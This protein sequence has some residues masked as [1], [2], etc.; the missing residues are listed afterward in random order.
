LL[1]VTVG[2]VLLIVRF[3]LRKKALIDREKLRPFECGFTPKNFPRIPLSI[4]FFLVSLV[5]LVFDVELI[6]I[7]PFIK[8]LLF[9][10]SINNLLVILIFIFFLLSGLFYEINQG[11][12]RW[13]K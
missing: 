7:F 13:A 4:R 1:R 9:L 12:L 6:L 2:G 3:L 8:K 10:P 5:F 11:T